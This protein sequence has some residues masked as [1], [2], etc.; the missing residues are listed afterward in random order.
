[1]ILQSVQTLYDDRLQPFALTVCHRAEETTNSQWTV[2]RVLAIA[3]QMQEVSIAKGTNCNQH[4]IY[5]C[6]EPEGFEGFL[7]DDSYSSEFWVQF[8]QLVNDRAP[9]WDVTF[10]HKVNRCELAV[11]LHQ[12]FPLLQKFCLGQVMHILL[13]ALSKCILK[14]RVRWKSSI[15]PYEALVCNPSTSSADYREIS[16][17]HAHANI[18]TSWELLRKRT[19]E[20]LRVNWRH[21][22]LDLA[23]MKCIFAKRFGCNLSEAYFG[24]QTLAGLF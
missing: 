17:L 13:V 5:L 11:M 24:Y 9:S 16:G 2:R 14:H 3:T 22:S 7:F 18:V 4:C 19:Q 21:G 1:M 20:I 12:H 10:G 15:G 6:N 23:M 8:T